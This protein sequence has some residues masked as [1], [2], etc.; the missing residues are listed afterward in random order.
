[1]LNYLIDRVGESTAN[2]AE[3]DYMNLG[4][5]LRSEAMKFNLQAPEAFWTCH[6]ADIGR[7]YNGCGPDRWPE[8]KRNICSYAM[9]LYDAAVAVHDW[10]FQQSD[11]TENGFAGANTRFYENMRR[12]RAYEFPWWNV[13]RYSECVMWWTKAQAANRMCVEYGWSGWEEQGIKN[14]EIKQAGFSRQ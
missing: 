6:P 4:A 13:A 3:P 8:W 10:E 9:R 7:A 5:T 1:M 12:I 2:A 14:N 11:G